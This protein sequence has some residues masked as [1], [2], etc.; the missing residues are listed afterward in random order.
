MGDL[1]TWGRE[2]VPFSLDCPYFSFVVKYVVSFNIQSLFLRFMSFGV[3]PPTEEKLRVAFFF[4]FCPHGICVL[5]GRLNGDDLDVEE[6]GS[7][8]SASQLGNCCLF[9]EGNHF[10]AQSKSQAL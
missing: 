4:T 6:E 10:D 7:L 5:V 3:S 2:N 1:K 8:W 9:Q